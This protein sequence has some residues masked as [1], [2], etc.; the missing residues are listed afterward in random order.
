[1]ELRGGIELIPQDFSN[2]KPHF[3]VKIFFNYIN[4]KELLCNKRKIQTIPIQKR[5]GSTSLVVVRLHC[6][7]GFFFKTN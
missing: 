6:K 1:M 7:N 2:F 4:C 3:I 5:L